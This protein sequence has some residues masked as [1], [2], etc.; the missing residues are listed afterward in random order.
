LPGLAAAAVGRSVALDDCR[1]LVDRM[2][3]RIERVYGAT[4]HAN[5]RRFLVDRLWPR[6]I[7]KDA[8]D[9]EAWAKDASP[10]DELRRWYH[11]HD[12]KYEELVTRYR[13]ELDAHEEGWRPL[14]EAAREG[15]V[16]LLFASKD[17]ERNNALI[18]R[19]YLE[20]KMRGA[21]KTSSRATSTRKTT[22]SKKKAATKGAS[23]EKKSVKKAPRPSKKGA[24]P[25]ARAAAAR[26]TS[27]RASASPARSRPRAGARRS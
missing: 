16:V 11:Q 24:R 17:V 25:R 6:G 18:L 14:L 19:D 3:I 1:I 7:R 22:T 15:D 10:S 26:T 23:V 21:K 2:S 9:L 5:E 13:R 12:G 8:I 4:I 27:A 20:E